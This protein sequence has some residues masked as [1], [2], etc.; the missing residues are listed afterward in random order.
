MPALADRPDPCQTRGVSPR[1]RTDDALVRGAATGDESSFAEIY[2]RYHQ[3]VYRYC[4][5]ILRDSED[6]R[7]VLQSTMERALRS[8]GK[9]QTEGGLRAW[10]FRI[11][12]NEA[13]T[14]I[15]KRPAAGEGAADLVAADAAS[16]AADRQRLRQL[17]DDL[18][19]LP[20]RQRCALVLRELSGLDSEEIGSALEVSPAAAKQSVY[21]ARV[22]LNALAD[23][24]DMSC[25]RAQQRISADDGR[26]LRGRRVKAHVRD[27][28]ICQ[29]FAAGIGTR[30]ADFPCL[31]PMLGA[32]AAAKTLAAV[33][34][35]TA[36]ATPGAEGGGP[37]GAAAPNGRRFSRDRKVTAAAAVLLLLGLGGALAAT[38]S[39]D[40][41]V[42][43]AAAPAV[44][45]EKA[46][47]GERAK[48]PGPKPPEARTGG[49]AS[50]PPSP[51][52]PLP[53]SVTGY[54][55]LDPAV[56]TLL[57]TS[58]GGGGGTDGSPVASEANGG[59]ASG[60]DGGSS[61]GPGP[62]GVLA[63]TGLDVGLLL[64]AAAGLLAAGL[65]TRRVAREPSA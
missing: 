18:G 58:H 13:M 52:H 43:A 65:A 1:G 16:E 63:F 42:G 60:G 64:L 45:P 14:A 59:P 10:L 5:S 6:A 44:A 31:F 33:T 39:G 35:S 27:C 23:G 11:A 32:A 36:A 56:T 29:A 26:R 34:G 3:P 21:E 12:H 4:V 9:Q 53:S 24:R 30:T 2:E 22:A 50:S 54:S 41:P 57:D 8:I 61:S 7:D 48:P 19:S 17:V 37:A 28:V 62:G 15:G 55:Q 47:A 51:S 38:Q 46:Q 49:P 20:E 40:E 25:E